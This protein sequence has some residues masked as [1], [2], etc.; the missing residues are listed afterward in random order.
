MSAELERWL[1]MAVLAS[2]LIFGF[3]DNFTRYFGG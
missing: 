3:I 2:V 1:T